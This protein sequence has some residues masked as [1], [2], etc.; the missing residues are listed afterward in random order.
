MDDGDGRSR[1]RRRGAHKT[2]VVFGNSVNI[3][4]DD[5]EGIYAAYNEKEQF[6]DDVVIIGGETKCFKIY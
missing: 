4:V 1:W 2:G 6:S 5:G 3:I